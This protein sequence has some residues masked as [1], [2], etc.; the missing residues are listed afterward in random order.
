MQQDLFVIRLLFT[1]FSS[2]TLLQLIRKNIKIT[3]K[4]NCHL[5]KDNL[6]KI[7]YYT[8]EP[9]SNIFSVQYIYMMENIKFHHC[10]SLQSQYQNFGFQQCFKMYKKT[11]KNVFPTCLYTIVQYCNKI[12][13]LI[14]LSYKSIYQ[15]TYLM[16]FC[17]VQT[18]FYLKILLRYPYKSYIS[19]QIIKI[20]IVYYYLF[21]NYLSTF[22]L[23]PHNICQPNKH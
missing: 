23:E 21:N 10:S 16:I 7:I 14:N 9:K 18:T 2:N 13:L 1:T 20:I 8:L 22:Q 17:F 4:K 6:Q 11:E 3:K 19:K 15:K 5:Q 12:D